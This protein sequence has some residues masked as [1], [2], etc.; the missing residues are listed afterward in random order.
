MRFNRNTWEATKKRRKEI[1]KEGGPY[2]A[3][4]TMSTWPKEAC[5]ETQRKQSQNQLTRKR[6]C[7]DQSI[8]TLVFLLLEFNVVCELY[9]GYSELLG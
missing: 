3:G 1:R 7:K 5:I 9:L 2:E 6:A 8:Q 4:R